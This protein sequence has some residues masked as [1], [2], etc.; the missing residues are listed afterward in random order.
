MS[1]DGEGQPNIHAAGIALDRRVE[2]LF[3]FSKCNDLV[4]TLANVGAGHA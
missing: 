2:K 4:E 3:D 1:R